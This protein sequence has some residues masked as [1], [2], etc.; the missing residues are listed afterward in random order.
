MIEDLGKLSED[1][2]DFVEAFKASLSDNDKKYVDLVSEYQES[3]VVSFSD[4]KMYM[5][6]M[7]LYDI[8]CDNY[9]WSIT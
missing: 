4:G 5:K 3:P 2:L 6:I 1:I 8:F 9:K 7:D